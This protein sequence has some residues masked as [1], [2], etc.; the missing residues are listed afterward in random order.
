MNGER[1]WRE[2]GDGVTGQLDQ[3]NEQVA[4]LDKEINR[5]ARED[6]RPARR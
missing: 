4:L 3:L 2:L 5:R 1:R 6:A